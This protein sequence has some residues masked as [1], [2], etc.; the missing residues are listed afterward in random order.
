MRISNFSEFRSAGGAGP[1]HPV[2]RG[3]ATQ[4]AGMSGDESGG[5]TK[6]PFAVDAGYLR[7]TGTGWAAV[8]ALSSEALFVRLGAAAGTSAVHLDGFKVRAIKRNGADLVGHCRHLRVQL[9]RQ[10]HPMMNVG[11]NSS[12]SGTT[13]SATWLSMTSTCT[14]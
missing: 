4:I 2:F 7:E 3:G 12:T 13:I 8:A 10:P 11:S 1:W 14:G 6:L 9:A 5:D